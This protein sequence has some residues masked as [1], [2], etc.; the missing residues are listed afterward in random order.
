MSDVRL[1]KFKV[2]R[3]SSLN[4][5]SIL[6]TLA[7]RAKTDKSARTL[8]KVRYAEI[9]L[10]REDFLK[11]HQSVVSALVNEENSDL[12]IEENTR[13]G[14]LNEFFAVKSI[15]M[16]LF[17]NENVRRLTQNFNIDGPAQQNSH[18][19][20]PKMEVPKFNG[21]YKVFTTFLDL[22]DALI[23][24]NVTLSPV[25]KFNYLMSSLEGQPLSLVRMLP[26]TAENYQTAYDTLVERYSNKRIRAQLHWSAIESSTK[27][28]A[29]NSI[30]LRKLLDVFSEN[31]AAL[32]FE[33]SCRPMGF[34]FS[35]D[36]IKTLR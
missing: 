1:R 10:V 28:S 11:H 27:I 2:S 36:V 20:L 8:F 33:F 24:N 6:H 35:H 22:F 19:R 15:Y 18:A 34:Y 12:D 29:N 3:N 16:E 23:H 21:D 4:E 25:E 14:F 30:A 26:L 31:L 5:M 7:E 13:E 32:N 17:E 9:D